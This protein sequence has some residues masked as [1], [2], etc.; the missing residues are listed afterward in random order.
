MRAPAVHESTGRTCSIEADSG[1]LGIYSYDDVTTIVNIWEMRDD[2][3]EAWYS[4]ERRAPSSALP[5]GTIYMVVAV[6]LWRP[7]ECDGY[8]RR[9]R[10]RRAGHR[11]RTAGGGS[12]ST[13]TT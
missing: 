1:A 5:L 11:S 13:P 8:R 4:S 7:L 12:M 10:R 3:S 2:E 6:R 9:Q